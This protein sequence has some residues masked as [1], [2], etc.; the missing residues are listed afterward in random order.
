MGID[1]C[2]R[3][4]RGIPASGTKVRAQVWRHKSDGSYESGGL[5]CETR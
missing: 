2:P 4:V 5:P 1:G 3:P